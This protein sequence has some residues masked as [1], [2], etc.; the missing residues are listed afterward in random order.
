MTGKL[1]IRCK[2]NKTG[3]KCTFG[4]KKGK[5]KKVVNKRAMK[6]RKGSTKAL[7]LSLGLRMK[8]KKGALL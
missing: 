3:A 7:N 6:I 4:S 5:L 8:S 1:N 2:T